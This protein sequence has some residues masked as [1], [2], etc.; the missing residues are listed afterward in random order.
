MTC[1]GVEERKDW[2][3]YLPF[4]E[5]Q[6]KKGGERYWRREGWDRKKHFLALK[7]FKGKIKPQ[8][9]SL[10]RLSITFSGKPCQLFPTSISDLI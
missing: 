8:H 10:F 7:R 5:K 2:L 4:T 3:L 1:V 6:R 9:D